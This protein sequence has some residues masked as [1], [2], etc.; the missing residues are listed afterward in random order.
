[1]AAF[2]LVAAAAVA[3]VLS[4]SYGPLESLGGVNGPA[5]GETRDVVRPETYGEGDVMVIDARKG[6]TFSF[7]FDVDNTGRLPLT[8]D[9]F[10]SEARHVWI[11]DVRVSRLAYEESGGEP[12]FRPLEGAVIPAGETRTLRATVSMEPCSENGASYSKITGVDLRYGYGPFSRTQTVEMPFGLVM[13][14]DMPPPEQ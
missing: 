7:I 3:V 9:A 4:R 1:V 10:Q 13:L 11:S 14:C 2:A 12:Q 8:F 6:G 5:R